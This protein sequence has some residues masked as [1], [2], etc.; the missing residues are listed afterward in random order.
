MPLPL[1]GIFCIYCPETPSPEPPHSTH[2]VSL[3]VSSPP[4]GHSRATLSSEKHP[5]LARLLV[6]L[7]SHSTLLWSFITHS[8]HWVTRV[9]NPRL[10][11]KCQL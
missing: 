3:V 2:T 11:G 6:K 9:T 1:S 4:S 5:S 7:P 8:G 10:P